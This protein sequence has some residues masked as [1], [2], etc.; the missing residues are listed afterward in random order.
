MWP[1][2]GRGSKEA[3]SDEY[4]WKV[5]FDRDELSGRDKPQNAGKFATT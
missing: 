2:G 5:T 1:L 4:V 3:K